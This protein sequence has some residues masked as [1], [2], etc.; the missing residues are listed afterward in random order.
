MCEP[1]ENIECSDDDKPIQK[2]GF[3]TLEDSKDIFR[4]I[5]NRY[6]SRVHSV[7]DP[8]AKDTSVVDQAFYRLNSAPEPKRED[9]LKD[10]LSIVLENVT[11]DETNDNDSNLESPLDYNEHSQSTIL[12]EAVLPPFGNKELKRQDAFDIRQEKISRQDA[13]DLSNFHQTD[14][15]SEETTVFKNEVKFLSKS[16][17]SNAITRRDR[18]IFSTSPSGMYNGKQKSF[19]LEDL[20]N[21]DQFKENNSI[22]FCNL[23]NNYSD[24]SLFTEGSDSVFLSP[25]TKNYDEV[26]G[27]GSGTIVP[28]ITQ[29]RDSKI[30]SETLVSHLIRTPSPLKLNLGLDLPVV[31]AAAILPMA[32]PDDIKPS[33]VPFIEPVKEITETGRTE[34]TVKPMKRVNEGKLKSAI[35]RIIGSNK[36]GHDKGRRSSTPVINLKT[37]E[38]NIETLNKD[39]KM[40]KNM[41]TIEN[42]EYQKKFR[43]LKSERVSYPPGIIK[44]KT[45]EPFKMDI[46]FRNIGTTFEEVDKPPVIK[47]SGNL[48]R[49]IGFKRHRRSSCPAMEYKVTQTAN[50]LPKQ[51][52]PSSVN[53]VN[54][55]DVRKKKISTNKLLEETADLL[56]GK[57]ITVNSPEQHD[58]MFENE[59]DNNDEV[60]DIFVS[61]ATPKPFDNLV[62]TVPPLV[63]TTEA[64]SESINSSKAP[65]EKVNRLVA[66]SVKVQDKAIKINYVD[67]IIGDDS[68]KLVDVAVAEKNSKDEVLHSEVIDTEKLE[69]NL[70]VTSDATKSKCTN[71]FLD[72]IDFSSLFTKP[73]ATEPSFDVSYHLKINTANDLVCQDVPKVAISKPN[74]EVISSVPKTQER[75]NFHPLQIINGTYLNKTDKNPS[76][77][78]ISPVLIQP[79]LF[80]PD[81]TAS[82]T[83]RKPENR[84]ANVYYD[85]I[86]Q[87]KSIEKNIIDLPKGDGIKNEG[88]FQKNIKVKNLPFLSW[89]PFGSNENIA[90]SKTSSPSRVSPRPL[91]S[92][93]AKVVKLTKTPEFL[94]DNHYYQPMENVPFVINTS[95]SLTK[96]I[97]LQTQVKQV[98]P[99]VSSTNPFLPGNLPRRDSEENYYEEIG[100]PMRPFQTP[101]DNIADDEK[102]SNK[103][104]SGHD[105]F[106]SVTR[107]EILKVPRRPR[108]PKK[109]ERH[110]SKV[111]DEDVT[112]IVKEM[113]SITKSVISLSRAPSAKDTEQKYS[114][115]VGALVYKLEKKASEEPVRKLSLQGQKAPQTDVNTGSLPRDRKPYWRTQEH[116]RLSH[117]IRS[118]NDPP[119]P[120]PLRKLPM[121]V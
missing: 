33:L 60:K 35:T 81:A 62:T 117:P 27:S 84:V 74:N 72:G 12:A 103:F 99:P 112:D 64:T 26:D 66:D 88:Q 94:I 29:K 42:S 96:P 119:P 20:H 97:I 77:I 87:V 5:F 47:T 83:D 65:Q 121:D 114:G 53:E 45:L 68:K 46:P 22:E 49:L 104:Q 8:P 4:S 67:V 85:D 14:D 90:D 39:V 76:P 50:V 93:N 51:I 25:V 110:L 59:I 69:D 107:E 73:V 40:D 32:Y 28:I 56:D 120:R 38:P 100:E 17:S 82:E 54:V 21:M 116:K 16:D 48:E 15:F 55:V 57:V 71:P 106:S 79:I 98:E 92:P 18:T 10:K 102:L 52:I 9:I 89:K 19:S 23:N 30:C 13:L 63:G 95:Q 24:M 86:D 44:D 43:R 36:N 6:L 58:E 101:G 115:P 41:N 11:T 105:D 108:R 31:K 34:E 80:K 61:I 1:V 111:I 78:I 91:E 37:T 2:P 75:L 7:S 109:E 3:E 113:D 118:L 70:N